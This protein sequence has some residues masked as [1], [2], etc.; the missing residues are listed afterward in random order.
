MPKLSNPRYEM[1]AQR[2]ASGMGV[3]AAYAATGYSGNQQAAS[4]LRHHP[5]V[6]KLVDEL[7][8]EKIKV[9][10]R[11]TEKAIERV[12]SKRSINKEWIM[13]K[14]IENI[15]RAMQVVPPTKDGGVFR[16]E[17]SV[18][19]R[20]LELLGKEFGMFIERKEVGTPGEFAELDA[21]GIRRV[22]AERLAIL[23]AKA[24]SDNETAH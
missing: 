2:V 7:V 6:S 24:N 17:G 16:Y 22:I 14:L 12:A 23:S 13:N 15:E 18:A 20:A 11:T 21:T 10:Q 3:A 9:E 8:A 1:F 5:E 4:R 19:N